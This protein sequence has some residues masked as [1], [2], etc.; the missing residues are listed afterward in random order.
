MNFLSPPLQGGR[1]GSA[2]LKEVVV[3]MGLGLCG[4]IFSTR[5]ASPLIR[6]T[7]TQK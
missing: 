1:E 5:D 6:G 7:S 3:P 2:P 4:L